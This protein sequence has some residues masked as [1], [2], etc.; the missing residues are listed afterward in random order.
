MGDVYHYKCRG[1]GYDKEYF[2]GVGFGGMKTFYETREL[3]A[4][5]R[6]DAWNGAYGKLLQNIVRADDEDEL[7]LCAQ[8]KGE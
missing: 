8:T 1:C 6:Q 4:E 5:L 3:E 7:E 2:T